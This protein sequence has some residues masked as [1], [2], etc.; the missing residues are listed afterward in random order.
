V[1]EALCNLWQR[2]ESRHTAESLGR[3]APSLSLMSQDV[4]LV[5]DVAGNR[6][7][8]VEAE[9]WQNQALHESLYVTQLRYKGILELITID[10]A[11]SEMCAICYENYNDNQDKRNIL[12]IDC[13]HD[14]YQN[15]IK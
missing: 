5:I 15:C 4:P 14:F 13:T 12:R 9:F 6:R 10:K 8:S 2:R 3:R 7:R 1:T 11:R